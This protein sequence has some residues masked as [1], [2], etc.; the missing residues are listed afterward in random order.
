LAQSQHCFSILLIISFAAGLPFGPTGVALA[1]SI[2]SL[3]IVQPG[4][5]YFVSRKGPVS[6]LDLWTVVL[7]YL[8][9]WGAVCASSYLARMMV[10]DLSALSQLLLGI[11]V[12]V[13][14]G[15]VVGS[16]FA[17]IRH[18]ATEVT[19]ALRGFLSDD[20]TPSA[21]HHTRG[22]RAR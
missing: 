19:A 21:V 7:R 16:L 13:M 11:P 17:P 22:A 12:G 8:P 10:A 14:S 6:M 18:S 9:L 15:L 5:Y 1:F 2:W 20:A 4:L 3:V